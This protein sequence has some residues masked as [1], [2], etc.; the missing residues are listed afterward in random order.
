MSHLRSIDVNRIGRK[1]YRKFS[2][3]ADI[4]VTPDFTMID[5]SFKFTKLCAYTVYIGFYD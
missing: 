1:F 3:S 2:N 5:S 4:S